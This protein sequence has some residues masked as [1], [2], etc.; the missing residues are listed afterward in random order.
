[1]ARL[2]SVAAGFCLVI[3][4]MF[5]VGCG[6]N[7]DKEMADAEA[8][9]QA[10]KDA[11]AE[12]LPEYQ[13]AEQ[14]IEQAR[15]MMAAGDK[16]A[17]RALLEE[18]RFKAIEAEGKA[19]NQAYASTVDVD[20]AEQNLQSLSPA[21]SQYGLVDIFFDYDQS[22]ITFDSK[23]VLDQNANIIRSSGNKFQVVVIE[24]YCDIR[25]TEEY[26]LALGQRRADSAANYLIG[27]GISPS[28]VQAVSRGETD[29]F[30]PGT[31][32]YD[33]QQNRRAHFVPAVGSPSF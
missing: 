31:S 27:L 29:Q 9:L 33:Y 15:Q 26:N 24:G 2:C 19:K 17:A 18:A 23:P 1:M 6:S 16:D 4:L 28:K 20:T 12:G 5:A 21:G 13:A 10:A 25:G 14:L 3:T 8:A 30:A 11:G 22:A 7:L 32:E